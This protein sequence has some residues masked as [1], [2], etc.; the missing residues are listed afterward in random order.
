[1]AEGS[2]FSSGVFKGFK[3]IKFF[4]QTCV[5][6]LECSK[7]IP[8]GNTETGRYRVSTITTFS[9]KDTKSI[10]PSVYLNT[11]GNPYPVVKSTRTFNWGY[12]QLPKGI[13]SDKNKYV[14]FPASYK[15]VKQNIKR[16]G[17]TLYG[18]L[19]FM[20]R[21]RLVALYNRSSWVIPASNEAHHIFP[22]EYGGVDAYGDSIITS[23]NLPMVPNDKCFKEIQVG[24]YNL[25]NGV[26]LSE[27][28]HAKFTL[29][30]KS[31]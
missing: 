24:K 1:M 27:P 3:K 10:S 30:W 22:V 7:V 12:A 19:Q 15:L 9:G 13:Q 18:C 28:D 8:I 6:K 14:P 5:Y 26:L 29:W 25:D 2:L 4:T 31:F 23:S 11:K 20:W 17:N 21:K 16:K